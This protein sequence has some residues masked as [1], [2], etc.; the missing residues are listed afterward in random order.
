M[1]PSRVSIDGSHALIPPGIINEAS[2]A[3][4]NSNYKYYEEHLP[5]CE[6]TSL[7][8]SKEHNA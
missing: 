1:K 3:S 4:C 7:G 8:H 2:Q 6:R 5:E